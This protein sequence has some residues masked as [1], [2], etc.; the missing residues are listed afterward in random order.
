M[1]TQ[2][3]KLNGLIATGTV[4]I[5]RELNMSIFFLFHIQTC[6]VYLDSK[7]SLSAFSVLSGCCK[8]WRTN[9]GC[10]LSMMEK[11]IPSLNDM[12]FYI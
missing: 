10:G 8:S 2:I 6:P 1:S 11:Q 4:I 12:A 9:F 7:Y 3:H 5:C